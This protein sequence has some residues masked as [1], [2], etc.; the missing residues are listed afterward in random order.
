MAPGPLAAREYPAGAWTGTE[1]VITG[2]VRREGADEEVVI[3][4]ADTAAYD[5][6][7]RRWRVLPDAPGNRVDARAVWTGSLMVVVG[8]GDVEAGPTVAPRT[9]ALD[10]QGAGEWRLFPPVPVGGAVEHLVWTG[11]EV[12][13]SVVGADRDDVSALYALDLT[14]AEPD[15]R[16]FPPSVTAAR[17]AALFFTDRPTVAGPSTEGA[18]V[19]VDFDFD[20][21]RYRAAAFDLARAAWATLPGLDEAPGWEARFVLAG[22]ELVAVGRRRDEG[23]RGAPRSAWRVPLT[24]QGA[25]DTAAT[26]RGE[27]DPSRLTTSAWTGSRWLLAGGGA[28]GGLYDPTTDTWGGV[29]PLDQTE[30][31]GAASAWTGE[32]LLV[33]GGTDNQRAFADGLEVRPGG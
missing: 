14:G 6:T 22:D 29:P 33:W 11:R 13:A 10:P 2:G 7:E 31:F 1:L 17:P 28:L 30:R 32:A 27:I 21:G 26:P 15:W 25:W 5:P 16:P 19:S 3:G 9:L 24:E 12:V 23:S 4:Y 18:L 8:G 20:T